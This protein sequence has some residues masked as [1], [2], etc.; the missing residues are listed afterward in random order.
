MKFIS[1]YLLVLVLFQQAFSQHEP[2]FSRSVATPSPQA[3]ALAKYGDSP[4]SL[5][6]GT[7]DITSH[8]VQAYKTMKLAQVSTCV[9]H[10]F[11]GKLLPLVMSASVWSLG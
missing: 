8:L 9:F 6:Y 10:C 5:S 11:T 3:V 1:V 2:P 7:A 4:A